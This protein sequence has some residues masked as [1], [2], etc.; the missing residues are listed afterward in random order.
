MLKSK[1]LVLLIPCAS[2]LLGCAGEAQSPPPFELS[3]VIEGFYGPPW[4]HQDRLD[5]LQFMGRVG[6]D[7]Y[8][9]APKDDPYHRSRWREAY[10]PDAGNQLRELVATAEGADVELWYA[11][12]P[13]LTMTCS[14]STDYQDLVDKIDLVGELGV[15]HFGLFL[16]DVPPELSSA[17]DRD[18]FGTLAQAHVALT[19]RLHADLAARGFSLTFTPTTYT[20]A[21]GDRDYVAA[22]GAGVTS[23]VK[24]IWT[25]PDVASPTIS[26]EQAA[27][28]GAL[29]QRPPL[30]W[31]NYPVNDY[32][33]WRLFLGPFTGRAAD[34]ASA[35]AG[36]IA[37]PMNEAH[38]SMIALATLADYADDPSGYDPQ[39]SLDRALE[40]LYGLDA[41][42]LNPFLDAFGDYGWDENLFEP[43]Y[44]L[45]DSIP[46]ASIDGTLARLDD[47]L[48]EIG[49]RAAANPSLQPLRDEIAPFV[50]QYRDRMVELRD[51]PDYVER[52]GALLYRTDLDRVAPSRAGAA[53]TVDGRTSEWRGAD[54]RSLYR[55]SDRPTDTRAAFGYDD[56]F[57]YV[58]VETPNPNIRV[59]ED[60]SLGEGDHIAVVV[61]GDPLDGPIGG[62]DLF[63]LFPPPADGVE[64]V[65]T[66]LP[67][68]GFMAKWL[69]DNRALTF[70]EFHLSTFGTDP[71]PVVAPIAAGV[72]YAARRTRTGYAA[73]IAL[74]HQ[75][76][77]VLRLSLTVTS[78]GGGK[79]VASL[80]RRNYPAN[81]VT[82]AEIRLRD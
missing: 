35:T 31:D 60:L 57:L 74:P 53:V 38:A 40:A 42:L 22:V 23:E 79:R 3:G 71:S 25:G 76:R 63:L 39:R 78:M 5:M 24:I 69:A 51:S 62:D 17:A 52:D 34:L 13:G 21:W 37:N 1:S 68:Q 80:S 26:A 44:I 58:A 28:W 66:S 11:I 55:G 10:P 72:R 7:V 41:D 18:A 82:F 64:P 77:D 12:S 61:D 56:E 46:V 14:D 75:G 70:T 4:S 29:L 48:D 6:L 50:A 65:I 9:Y 30:L 15:E 59:R 36:I 20:D 45:A 19:N 32:A 27:N 54:W 73:E 16:D 8:I 81:P 49:A 67:F 47:A 33:R 43:L 2:L